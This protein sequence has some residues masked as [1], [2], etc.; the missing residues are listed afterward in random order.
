MTLLVCEKCVEIALTPSSNTLYRGSQIW[1]RK[2]VHCRPSFVFFL[3]LGF[4]QVHTFRTEN[5]YTN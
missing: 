2:G 3:K 4:N 5:S 1:E